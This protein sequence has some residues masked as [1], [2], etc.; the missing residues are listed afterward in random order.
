MVEFIRVYHG[1]YGSC[2]IT[3]N[4]PTVDKKC[5][6][7]RLELIALLLRSSAQASTQRMAGSE[8]SDL[9]VVT[10]RSVDLCCKIMAYHPAYLQDTVRNCSRFSLHT[11]IGGEAP[12]SASAV[13][14]S[15]R[16]RCSSKI[17]P[18]TRL[19]GCA[20]ASCNF[21]RTANSEYVAYTG[22]G[23]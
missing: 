7:P 15:Y 5:Y 13:G 19:S 22:Y 4:V 2:K 1:Y 9:Y 3:S 18:S 10:F 6:W 20:L 11:T 21:E 17:S 14:R 12:S 8:V 16:S 23:D